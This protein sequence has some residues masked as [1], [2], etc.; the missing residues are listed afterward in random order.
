MFENLEGET[1][2][3]GPTK[4]NY[5]GY[6]TMA[7]ACEKCRPEPLEED[8]CGSQITTSVKSCYKVAYKD[9]PFTCEVECGP[10]DKKWVVASQQEEGIPCPSCD[11]KEH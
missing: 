3:K 9:T 8:C 4:I 6:N 10:I 1:G 5:R 2:T 7:T 11:K